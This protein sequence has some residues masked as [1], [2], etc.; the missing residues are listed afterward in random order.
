MGG[1]LSLARYCLR[2][3]AFSGDAV[4]APLWCLCVRLGRNGPAKIAKACAPA[5]LIACRALSRLDTHLT[6]PAAI[7]TCSFPAAE[8]LLKYLAELPLQDVAAALQAARFNPM[9]KASSSD[10]SSE[11]LQS[12]LGYL[13][14]QLKQLKQDTRQACGAAVGAWQ[15]LLA[16]VQGP[17]SGQQQLPPLAHAHIL[18]ACPEKMVPS[19]LQH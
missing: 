18:C 11:R 12:R 5:P 9:P 8:L 6:L 17:T 4:V 7:P 2:A 3:V 13:L 1:S 16:C 10:S 19:H 15:T 14:K